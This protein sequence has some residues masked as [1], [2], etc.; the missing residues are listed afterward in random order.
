MNPYVSLLVVGSATTAALL[1]CSGGDGNDG[2]ATVPVVIGGTGVGGGAQS[3]AVTSTSTTAGVG[4][5]GVTEPPPTLIGGVEF[6][7]PS[8][9]FQGQLSV[10]MTAQ[11]GG[12]IRYTVDGLLPTAAS[13]L[14]AG[15]PL[16]LGETTELRAQV[17]AGGVAE[18]AVSTAIYIARSFDATSDLPLIIVD[19]YGGGFPEN[20]DVFLDAGFMVFE[21]VGGQAALSALPTVASRAGYHLRGQS[22]ANFEKTPYRVELWDNQDLDAD[23]PLLGMPAEADWALIGPYVD[24]TFIRNAFV[25]SLGRDQACRRLHIMADLE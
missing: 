7:V 19:G 14:Y 3:T 21:P 25:Y 5:T 16:N 10:G 15:T 23:Y 12:E 4:G 24:R 22:S 20:K 1:A 13:T 9:A 8:Q 2:G 18:S 11:S 6:S 17:F